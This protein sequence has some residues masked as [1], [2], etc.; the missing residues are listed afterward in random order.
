MPDKKTYL[1]ITSSYPASRSAGHGGGGVF[2]EHFARELARKSDVVVLTQNTASETTSYSEESDV[3]VVRF[4]WSGGGKPLST[5]RLPQ[6]FF[7]VGSV[8]ARGLW[9][10][11]NAARKYR[12]DRTLAIWALPS[13]MWALCLKWA[14]GFRTIL[15][16]SDPTF[17]ITKGTF[18]LESCCG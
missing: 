6:D 15:G 16:H 7:L 18:W 4:R 11:L 17:G 2:V 13:G 14:W 12:I 8:M 10:G 3:R 9:T 5:L 1:L